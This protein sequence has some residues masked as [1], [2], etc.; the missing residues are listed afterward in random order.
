MRTLTVAD[1]RLALDNLFTTPARLDLFKQTAAFMVY[2]AELDALRPELPL[3]LK[4]SRPM[5]K[6][7]DAADERHDGLGGALWLLAECIKKLPS[8]SAELFQ[9]A[10]RIQSVFI[11]NLSAL[12]AKY[13]KEAQTAK[14][15][16]PKAVEMKADLESIPTP[17]GRTAYAWVIEFLDSGDELGQLID[18]R[19]KV[20]AGEPGPEVIATRTRALAAVTRARALIAEEVERTSKLPKNTEA[21][22]FGYFDTLAAFRTNAK[23]DEEA[24]PA[25]PAAPVAAEGPK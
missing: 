14:A 25:P 23:N 20:E 6:D 17:D 18:E 16:R 15:N 22:L 3:T 5:V 12:R 1:L 10:E 21:I 24:P 11:P 2:G 7:L 8:T 19:S 9:K 13:K 4:G